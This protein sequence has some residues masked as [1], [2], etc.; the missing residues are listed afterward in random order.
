MP[1]GKASLLISTRYV[2]YPNFDLGNPFPIQIRCSDHNEIW[3]A[4]ACVDRSKGD[5][6]I[7]LLTIMI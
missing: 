3:G 1:L 7:G 2:R 5:M 4:L 6:D